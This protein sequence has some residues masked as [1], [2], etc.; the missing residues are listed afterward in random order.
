MHVIILW[1]GFES[2]HLPE[3]SKFNDGNAHRRSQTARRPAIC[4]PT[5]P[6][7]GSRAVSVGGKSRFPFLDT[8]T[9]KE[10]PGQW[11]DHNT[12]NFYLTYPYNTFIRFNL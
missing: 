5:V 7:Y 11:N 1:L 10:E 4:Q 8:L 6:A 2:K 9:P 3:G 12:S